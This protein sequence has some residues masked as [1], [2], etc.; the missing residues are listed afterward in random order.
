MERSEQ[1]KRLRER[2]IKKCDELLGM[3]RNAEETHRTLAEP[4]ETAQKGSI[5]D[6]LANLDSREK[7]EIEAIDHALSMMETGQYGFCEVCGKPITKKTQCPP[8]D[9]IMQQTCPVTKEVNLLGPY[10]YSSIAAS[11]LP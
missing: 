3:H 1:I 6:V 2:L 11:A 8:V 9:G 4:E 5:A 7:K 10:R